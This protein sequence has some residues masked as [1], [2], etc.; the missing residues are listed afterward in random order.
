[1]PPDK[2]RH[3]HRTD[4]IKTK[5]RSKAGPS[6]WFTYKKVENAAVDHRRSRSKN[7]WGNNEDK[8]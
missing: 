6:N 8:C 5:A 1:M 2:P 4:R 3:P 7:H